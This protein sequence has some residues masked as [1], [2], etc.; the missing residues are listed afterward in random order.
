[1]LKWKAEQGKYGHSLLTTALREYS[2]G[3]LA[4]RYDNRAAIAAEFKA[5]KGRLQLHPR[6]KER[7]ALPQLTLCRGGH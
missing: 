6:R 5:D 4:E 1:M 2:L 3:K 7:L